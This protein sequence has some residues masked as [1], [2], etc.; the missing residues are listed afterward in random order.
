MHKHCNMLHSLSLSLSVSLSVCLFVSLS[1]CCVPF[2]AFTLCMPFDLPIVA[3]DDYVASS[4]GISGSSQSSQ[5]STLNSQAL[6]FQCPF[7][8]QIM[9]ISLDW[10]FHSI[11]TLHKFSSP[12]PSPPFPLHNVERVSSRY[13]FLWWV[14]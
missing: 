8:R 11:A 1:G 6:L 4:C 7:K 14:E 12:F 2:A 9:G 3:T 10:I 13:W 5:L